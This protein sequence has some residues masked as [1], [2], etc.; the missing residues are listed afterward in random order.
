MTDN[1]INL[2]TVI[3]PN[4]LEMSDKQ[5]KPATSDLL[6][7]Y[8]ICTSSR[9]L[10]YRLLT[11]SN[12]FVE[13]ENS[14]RA[15]NSAQ[16]STKLI[17]TVFA[18]QSPAKEKK[19]FDQMLRTK[20]FS[21]ISKMSNRLLNGEGN[22]TL[23]TFYSKV[24]FDFEI[25][26]QKLTE[27]AVITSS[28]K[29]ENQN[30]SFLG[31]RSSDL[32]DLE[33]PQNS[34]LFNYSQNPSKHNNQCGVDSNLCCLDGSTKSSREFYDCFVNKP[35]KQALT[36]FTSSIRPVLLI[37]VDHWNSLFSSIFEKKDTQP[38]Q[39]MPVELNCEK[40]STSVKTLEIEYLVDSAASYCQNLDSLN[41]EL[42]L[43][44]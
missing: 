18:N 41:E 32:P 25:T 35:K 1:R 23:E 7:T 26:K 28:Q 2:S 29:N 22:L 10:D 27:C 13:C 16:G 44:Y 9:S 39:I 43:L 4:S 17:D 36:S 20:D 21:P 12:T 34:S 38:R 15:D 40:L 11:K 3:N 31:K 24:D 19:D 30:S 14:V 6:S 42:D 5:N 8:F 37:T 33:M